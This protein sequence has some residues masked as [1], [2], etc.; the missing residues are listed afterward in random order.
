LNQYILLIKDVHAL[1]VKMQVTV[2]HRVYSWTENDSV[3]V[4]DTYLP[5]TPA[6]YDCRVVFNTS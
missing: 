6:F 2:S 5:S 1:P 4:V 3:A